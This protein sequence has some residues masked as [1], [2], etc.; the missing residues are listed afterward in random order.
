M[1]KETFTVG[2]ASARPG[3]RSFGKLIVGELSDGSPVEMPVIVVNGANPGPVLYV[4]AAIHAN[5]LNG[6]EIIRRMV[7]EIDP[8]KLSGTII[9]VP[10]QNPLAFRAKHPLTPFFHE[11]GDIT[12]MWQA[13]PGNP[14]HDVTSIMTHILVTEAMS[15][16]EYIID[17]HGGFPADR[18]AALP[19]PDNKKAEELAKAFNLWIIEYAPPVK[20]PLYDLGKDMKKVVVCVELGHSEWLD[21]R[22]ITQGIKGMWNAL[23]HLK[24][25]EGAVEPPEK[26]PIYIMSS[27]TIRAG[28]GGWLITHVDCLDEVKKG[29]LL[30]TVYNLFDFEKTEEIRAPRDG[31]VLRIVTYP[32]VNRGSRVVALG[33]S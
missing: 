6:V 20:V 1:G 2:T 24:M 33:W 3:T 10:T 23:R 32:Q 26:P 13:F 16:A 11:K 29:H 4:G 22:R 15:K 7:P 19:M 31:V 18:C 14:N 27:M 25:I 30:A 17:L 28:K 5:E 8:Q 12:D 21:E 9:F